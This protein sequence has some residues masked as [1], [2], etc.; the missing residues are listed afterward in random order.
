M[1]KSKI[2]VSYSHK[3]SQALEQLQPFLKPLERDR[4]I[5]VFIDTG[6]KPGEDWNKKIIEALDTATAAVLFISQDFLASDFI[7]D[8]E[9]PRILAR[10][11]ARELT[12][13]PVFLRVSDV[14]NFDKL[15]RFQGIGTPDKPLLARN[16]H[17]QEQLYLELTERI[18]ELAGTVQTSTPPPEPPPRQL[19]PYPAGSRTYQLTVHLARHGNTL[20]A[21]YY[22]PGTD[23]IA[24][25]SHPWQ[26][27]PASQNPAGETL[28][29]LLFGTGESWEK[30]SRALFRQSPPLNP[31]WAPVRLRICTDNSVLLRLPWCLT[32]WDDWLLVDRG[33]E[34][35]TTHVI[36]PSE[37]CAT[38]APC[39]V[40]IVAPQAEVNG[41]KPDSEHPDAIKEV[42]QKVWP[43]GRQPDYVR[44]VRTR[45]AL[46][47]ALLG[48][49]SHL[50]LYV[51]G[52]VSGTAD[53]PALLLDDGAIRLTELA[54]R[55]SE[56]QTYPAV[57]YLNTPASPDP[58]PSP[59]RLLGEV[60]SLVIW[61]RSREWGPEATSQA[62]TWLSRWLGQGED[63]LTALHAIKKQ[64]DAG[65]AAT[66]AAHSTYRTWKT[67]TY[68]PDPRK[69]YAYLVL[70]RDE[71]KAQVGKH[72]KELVRSD[73]RRVMALVAYA[74]PGNLLGSLHEQLRHYLELEVA[75]VAEINWPPLQFPENRQNL[76]SNLEYELGLQLA[77]DDYEPVIKFVLRRHA[78]RVTGTGKKAVL[79]L[80]WGIFGDGAN[81]Q[82]ALKPSELET[83]LRF[84]SSFL[85]SHCPDDLR[86]VSYVAIEAKS[87]KLERLAQILQQYGWQNWCRHPAFRLSALPPLDNVAESHLYDYLVDGNTGCDPDIQSE[88]AER[89][90]A[91]KGG[92]FEHTIDLIR[93]AENGSWRNLL[94]KLR[95][96][97]SVT[98]PTD[99]ER[100]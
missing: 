35:T 99:D 11:A 58:G 88:V 25:G 26:D 38:Y 2:F 45:S 14:K 47:N 49:R 21:R 57:I 61:R 81:H 20:D 68:S 37:D 79:W 66:L 51:Y 19:A 36:D 34:F 10:E 15:A 12:V 85:C 24:A 73:K 28:F 91:A 50:L 6:I 41:I 40:L 31:I 74:A 97:Q 90:I 54:D 94:S 48:M 71:Q 7:Y 1:T 75:D 16:T 82:M 22:L 67:H 84:S 98:L 62:V 100:F 95:R 39:E 23:A 44:I 3:D 29:K 65:Q 96:E 18:R 9:L 72:L 4:L 5:E 55:C 60:A 93:E 17:E 78:P 80:N 27:I 42:L 13:L 89:L 63:P 92:D 53:R 33:W 46:E 76:Q 69:Q 87:D 86:I 77:P 83:W 43:T 8:K 32:K 70:D 59:G 64:Q 30:V 52:H 56:L